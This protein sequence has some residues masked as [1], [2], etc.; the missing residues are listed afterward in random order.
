MEIKHF[1]NDIGQRFEPGDEVVMIASRRQGVSIRP[2]VYLGVNGKYPV[3]EWDNEHFHYNRDTGSGEWKPS[4]SKS[5]LPLARIYLQSTP[6]IN[7]K[8]L[9]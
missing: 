1:V 3:C 8:H 2:A 7:F 6:L 4:R 5:T 9:G